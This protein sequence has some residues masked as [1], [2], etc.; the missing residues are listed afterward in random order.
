MSKSG[1]HQLHSLNEAL[2]ILFSISTP[3]KEAEYPLE[4]ALNK[5]CSRDIP[6][7]ID[8]PAFAKSAMDGYAVISSDTYYASPTRP[9]VLEQIGEILPGETPSQVLSSGKCIEIATGAPVPDGADGII[10]VEHTEKEAQEVRVFTSTSP[11]QHIIFPGSDITKSQLIIKKGTLLTARHTALL[12][13][14]GFEKIFC[15][16]A[17]AI[18]IASS[19]N[20]IVR[21]P[22]SLAPGQSY[23]IN[24]RALIDSIREYG[25]V[26]KD[27]GVIPD[28]ADEIEKVILEMAKEAD[29]ILL[30]GGSSLGTKD[31]ILEQ[32]N[33]IGQVLVHGIAVKPGKPTLIGKVQGKLFL[34]LP[35]HPASALSNYYI[36]IKPYLDFIHHLQSSIVPFVDARLAS[37]IASTIG[38]CEFMPVQLEQN[39]SD[40]IA[41]PQ[42]K[43]S[44]AIFPMMNSDGYIKIHENI[45]VLD[46]N[47]LVRVFLF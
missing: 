36:L 18:A 14:L 35:G 2:E 38:R 42:L 30:S 43:G 12:S 22:H 31:L 33:K 11:G 25:C 39:D 26:S 27:F 1:F 24:S 40:Y 47:T 21:P 23:D 37:K 16:Q 8:V 10:M 9:I 19:G 5:I 17:L 45:E 20:E 7:P 44:S 6:A 15:Y 32:I 13:G 34:G 29:I 28:D 4:Q 41:H 3:L 46:K